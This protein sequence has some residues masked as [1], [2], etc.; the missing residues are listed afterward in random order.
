MTQF[1]GR[2]TERPA[3]KLDVVNRKILELL[4][5]DGRMPASSIGKHVRLSKDAAAYRINVMK[6]RGVIVGFVPIINTLAIG[7]QTFQVFLLLDERHPKKPLLDHMIEHP[8]TLSVM[9]Y[10]DTWDV[11][12]TL[13]ARDIQEFDAIMTQFL[14]EHS[15]I[16]LEK[17]VNVDIREYINIQLPHSVEP[18]RSAAPVV[19]RLDELDIKLLRALATDARQSTYELG[20]K[21]NCS[22]DTVHN[23]MRRLEDDGV[24]TGFTVVPDL[25][26]LGRMWYTYAMKFKRFGQ[27]EENKLRTFAAQN[28]HIIHAVKTFGNWDVMLTLVPDSLQTYHDTIKE[29]K[30][31]FSDTIV[32]YQTWLANKERIYKP[33]AD[34]IPTSA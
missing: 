3:Q 13:V 4:A 11:G 31:L 33:M 26:A 32:S 16:V 34:I 9:E 15:D 30:K 18:T 22:P 28:P 20:R 19:C 12:W 6:E 17:E 5:K 27:L 8:N 23:R 2:L 1:N 14:G 24:I 7:Q 21:L 10:T 29:I 25:A